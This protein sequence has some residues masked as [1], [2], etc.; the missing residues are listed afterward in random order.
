LRQDTEREVPG[1]ILEAG[2]DVD[3]PNEVVDEPLVL[4]LP[5][6]L[7]VLPPDPASERARIGLFM[8]LAQEL[9][10][11]ADPAIQLDVLIEDPGI[12]L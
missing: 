12:R 5:A 6:R 11:A 7:R 9:Q 4:V 10:E 1:C 2:A 8:A 3:G